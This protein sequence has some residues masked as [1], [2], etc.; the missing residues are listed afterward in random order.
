MGRSSPEHSSYSINT[1]LQLGSAISL[2]YSALTPGSNTWEAVLYLA[3]LMVTGFLF[4]TTTVALEARSIIKCSELQPVE[5]SV[6]V[7][8]PAYLLRGTSC[9][10]PRTYDAESAEMKPLTATL[11]VSAVDGPTFTGLSSHLPR[12]DL[13][14]CTG[15]RQSQVSPG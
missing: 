7:Q 15:T 3:F 2:S 6:H 8:S 11:M 10:T 13:G 4:S 9:A 14:T 5:R 12:T 1:F